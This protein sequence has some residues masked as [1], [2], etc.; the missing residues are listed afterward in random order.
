MNDITYT[1]YTVEELVT[2]VSRAEKCNC[3][4]DVVYN[5]F[6]IDGKSL[7][8]VMNVGLGHP[9]KIICHS[10]TMSPEELIKHETLR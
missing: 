6:V 7:I 2:F 3:D 1:F 8:G 4:I 10:S 9:V 5:H